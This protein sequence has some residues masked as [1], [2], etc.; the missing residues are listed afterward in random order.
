MTQQDY[1]NQKVTILLSY[2]RVPRHESLKNALAPLISDLQLLQEKDFQQIGG[3][4]WPVE[5]YFSSDW[6]FLA[7]CLEMKVASTKH[8][9]PWCDCS[10]DDINNT[11]KKIIKS[12]ETIKADFSQV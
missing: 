2:I 1:K 5:L 11:N 4:H 3:N 9:C 10:K 7:T 12:M 8:F 6:K